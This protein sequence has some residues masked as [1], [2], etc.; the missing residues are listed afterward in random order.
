MN[1][2]DARDIELA[3]SIVARYSKQR[4]LE[5]VEVVCR[6]PKDSDIPSSGGI[7]FPTEGL[8]AGTVAVKPIREHLLEGI[9]I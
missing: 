7:D 2:G 5:G 9:R 4:G 6:I 8:T 1:A 3:A